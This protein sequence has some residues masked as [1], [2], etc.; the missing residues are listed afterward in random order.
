MERVTLYIRTTKKDGETRLRYRLT[1]GRAV[2]L[3]YRSGIMASVTELRKYNVDGTLKRRVATRDEEIAT[4][5]ARDMERIRRV[6]REMKAEGIKKISSAS[7]RNRIDGTISA[8]VAREN[9]AERFDRH[10]RELERNGTVSLG[11]LKV[12]RSV[13]DKLHRYLAVTGRKWVTTPE[14]TADDVM[15]FKDYVINEYLYISREAFN[16]EGGDRRL[17]TKRRS[18]NT[19]SSNMRALQAFFNEIEGRDEI[20]KSP[21]RKLTRQRRGEMV[22]EQYDTPFALNAGEVAKIVATD[23]PEDLQ[24][25]RDAFLLQTATGCRVGDLARLTMNNVSTGNDGVVYISYL[26]HKTLHHQSERSETVTPLM[27]WAVD[28]VRRTGMK[29]NINTS[30]GANGYNAKIRKLLEHCGIDRNISRYNEETGAMERV[31]L[32]RAASSK[33]C[34]RTHVDIATKA[35]VNMYATGLHKPGS[36]AVKHYSILEPGDLFTLLCAAFGQPRYKAD[37]D[38]NIIELIH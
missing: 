33:L 36:R 7:L 34:R 27:K 14:F 38:F 23:V 21:F 16:T 25:T 5:I 26:P 11:R 32:C 9:V 8:P 35:Q 22:K 19:A 18:V 29:L 20:S 13:A 37:K 1:E 15:A 17:P 28:I 2:Q 6:Y 31:S 24:S 4:A 12:Y 3:F 10:V 30:S